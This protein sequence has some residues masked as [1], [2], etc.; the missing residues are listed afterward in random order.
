MGDHETITQDQMNDFLFAQLVM[1]FQ[2]AAYQQMG[3]VMNPVTNKIERDLDQAKGSINILGML[4]AKTRGNLNEDEQKML[5]HALYELRMNYVEEVKKGTESTD[6]EAG[7]EE[8][9]P[10][11]DE[12]PDDASGDEDEAEGKERED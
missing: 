1:M 4:E 6:P 2:G 8:E 9:T 11:D 5:E 12:Q 7:A 10:E 3:K